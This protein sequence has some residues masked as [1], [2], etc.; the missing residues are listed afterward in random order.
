MSNVDRLGR[1]PADIRKQEL[2][3][4]AIIRM[5]TAVCYSIQYGVDE[6][7]LDDGLA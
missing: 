5:C 3:T 1:R 6:I 2:I 7:R 4:T